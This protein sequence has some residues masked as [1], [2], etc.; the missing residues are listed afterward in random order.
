M[1]VSVG[2]NVCLPRGQSVNINCVA[3]S[4][5][6]PITYA[7]RMEPNEAVISTNNILT[8]SQI[9]T[10]NCTATNLVGSDSASTTVFGKEVK[11][12]G[13]DNTGNQ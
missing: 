8:V 10:Y 2:E 7:W 1:N 11:P 12:E 3:T 5:S 9:G 13:I 4:G 6:P